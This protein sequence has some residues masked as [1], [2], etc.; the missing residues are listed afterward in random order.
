V[1]GASRFD[2]KVI[3]TLDAAAMAGRPGYR[4]KVMPNHRIPPEPFQNPARGEIASVNCN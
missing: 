3:V 1:A 4:T 2:A